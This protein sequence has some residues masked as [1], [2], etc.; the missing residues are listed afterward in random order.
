[1]AL[2]ICGPLLLAAIFGA[3][4]PMA[5]GALPPATTT[6]LLTVGCLLAAMASSVSLGLMALMLIGQAPSLA[7]DGRWSDDV[8][9]SHD[10]LTAPVSVAAAALVV[11]LAAR[12][13]RVATRR[14]LAMRATCRLARELPQTGGELAVIDSAERHA[15]ALPGRSSR[16]VVT[17]GLLRALNT[18][19]RRAVLAHERSHLRHRH[20][21]HQSATLLAASVNPLL[22]RL[23]G[24]V[25]RSCERWA[26]EDAAR[27]CPRATVADALTRLATGLRLPS[28]SVLLSA[29][30][31]DVAH[32][33]TAL[34]RPPPRLTLWR[35]ASLSLLLAA[36][37]MAVAVAMQ[38]TD[39]IFDLA[40]TAYRAGQR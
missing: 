27:I 21:L 31:G 18:E 26:D 8:L 15:F 5:S 3:T 22:C 19:Q 7:A 37:I 9:R 10:Q 4:A 35:I 6:W 24:A 16:I 32:R 23:P 20:H 39:R 36:L 28:S 17:S 34:L 38:N 33:V 40:Q 1:M 30:V 14:L 11:L 29:A 12:F 2:W 13:T 25:E